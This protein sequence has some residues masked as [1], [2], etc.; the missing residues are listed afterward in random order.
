MADTGEFYVLVDATNPGVVV[1][2]GLK[3]DNVSLKFSKLYRKA[4]GSGG[5]DLEITDSG[6]SQTLSFGG[7][8]FHCF[9]PYDALYYVA[10]PS[11]EYT[12]VFRGMDS[13]TPD[14]SA[15]DFKPTS[16]D[17]P[18]LRLVVDNTK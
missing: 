13:T 8:D 5:N 17:K 6:I 14:D 7:A 4:G 10:S 3:G 9:L 18:G 16:N 15:N 2:E 11:Q 1:P 12:A